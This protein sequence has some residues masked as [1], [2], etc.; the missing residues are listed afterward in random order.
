MILIGMLPV[1][2]KN[3]KEFSIIRE[4]VQKSLDKNDYLYDFSKKM[5]KNLNFSLKIIL[6]SY[7]IWQN[8]Y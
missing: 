5:K 1:A 4:R 6:Q 7:R 8:S 2:I 3:T